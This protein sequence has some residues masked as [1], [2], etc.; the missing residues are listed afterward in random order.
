MTINDTKVI[1]TNL[2]NEARI[3]FHRAESGAL[4]D[5]SGLTFANFGITPLSPSI[6]AM[7]TFNITGVGLIGS[8]G[9]AS[10]TLTLTR[11]SLKSWVLPAP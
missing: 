9:T 2:V 4:L 8:G 1:S 10:A 5:E 3:S 7:G 6:P 11:Q